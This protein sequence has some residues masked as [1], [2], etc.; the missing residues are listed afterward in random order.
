MKNYSWICL[1]FCL[2]FLISAIASVVVGVVTIVHAF[3][4][5]NMTTTQ[6]IL[7]MLSYGKNRVIILSMILSYLGMY[8]TMPK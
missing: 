6:N 5:P 1:L 8:I 4:N 7:W 2:I 3:Q